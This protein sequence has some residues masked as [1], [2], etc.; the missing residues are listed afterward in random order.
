MATHHPKDVFILKTGT[1]QGTA[2]YNSRE[3][4]RSILQIV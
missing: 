3:V 4:K 1:C 2:D